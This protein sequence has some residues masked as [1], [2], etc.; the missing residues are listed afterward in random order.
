MKPKSSTAQTAGATDDPWI[1]NP[2]V[3]DEFGV[4][5][6]TLWRW[7][8]SEAMAALGWP[9][10][11]KIGD[12]KFRSRKALDAFKDAMFKRAVQEQRAA[13]RAARR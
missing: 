12:R 3:A 13:T 5:P 8:A 9:P 2:Q 4:T 11:I 1:P 6:M 7:D 10:P